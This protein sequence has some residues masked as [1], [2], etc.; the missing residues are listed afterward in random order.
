M[1]GPE[2][3]W[4]LYTI[5]QFVSLGGTKA[6]P[7]HSTNIALWE[8]INV[9]K[10]LG[11][12]P[13]GRETGTLAAGDTAWSELPSRVGKGAAHYTDRPDGGKKPI[14]NTIYQ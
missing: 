5:L 11:V 6:H 4:A 9:Y 1:V 7:L 2:M 3:V 8:L 10:M 14:R 12:P 13:E